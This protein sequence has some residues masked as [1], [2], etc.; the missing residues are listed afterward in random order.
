MAKTLP[1]TGVPKQRL[2]AEM[3]QLRDCDADWRSG[4]TFSMVFNPGEQAYAVAKEAYN[5]F[6]AENALNP[7]AFPSLRRMEQECVAMTANLLSG[8]QKVAGNMTSGG[9]ESILM[10]VKTA[11]DWGR[12]ERGIQQP[13][14][15]APVSAHPAFDKACHYF[16]VKMRHV[17]V[18]ADFRADL[19]AMRDA[20]NNDTVMLVGSAPQYAQGVIDPISAIAELAQSEKLLCHVD[21]CIGGFLLPFVEQLG[22]TVTPWDFRVP[23]VTSISC[24]LHKFAYTPKGASVVLYR[25]AALRRHQFHVYS[26]WTGG[27]YASPTMAGTRPGGGIA[28]A[29]AM[30]NY[31]GQAGY[32]KMA[33]AT[34]AATQAIREG[35]AQID[36]IEV[37]GQPEMSILGI[38]HKGKHTYAIGDEMQARGWLLDRQQNPA[39]LHL[40]V[41]AGHKDIAP[42]FLADLNEAMEAIKQQPL[43]RAVENTTVK[44]ASGA[45]QLLPDKIFSAISRTAAAMGSDAVPKRSAAMYGM[46][47]ELPARGE[48]DELVLDALERLNSLPED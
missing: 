24:D 19:K 32:L 39:S 9:T 27:I 35:L 7:S 14:I 34:M 46:M 33:K 48:L 4:K 37:L 23:G 12:K 30:L 29:W 8:N 28:A 47:A 16:G 42:S 6:M 1:A 22:Y 15:I 2:L 45:A 25:N 31:Q 13:E 38:A 20:I 26:G 44:L 40:T 21:A 3:R 5:L 18:D 43:R 10:A 36:D 17:P 11:R 41:S